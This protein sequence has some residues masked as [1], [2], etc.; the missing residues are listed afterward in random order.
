MEAGPLMHPKAGEE[1]GLWCDTHILGPKDG[2]DSKRVLTL[3]PY[4]LAQ[5]RLLSYFPSLSVMGLI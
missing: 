5:T 3:P 1:A 2:W 4:P